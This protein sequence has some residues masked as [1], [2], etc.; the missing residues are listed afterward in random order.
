MG[1]LGAG[2][3]HRAV[4][5]PILSQQPVPDAQEQEEGRKDLCFFGGP[6]V[7]P[8]A[9]DSHRGLH[10]APETPLS[11]GLTHSRML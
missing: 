1:K 9:K 7:L 3:E 4:L 5:D 6:K 11:L 2:D 8:P 10:A